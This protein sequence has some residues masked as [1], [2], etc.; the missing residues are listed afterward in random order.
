MQ[1]ECIYRFRKEYGRSADIEGVFIAT[2]EDIENIIGTEVYFGEIAG[3]HSEVSLEMEPEMFTMIT[4]EP[5]VVNLFRQHQ[6]YSG[7]NPFEYIYGD[8]DE[9]DEEDLEDDE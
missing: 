9:D 6:L 2:P 8:E 5:L 7:I 1:E 3:K 4:D